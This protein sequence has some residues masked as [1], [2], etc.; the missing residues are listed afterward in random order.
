MLIIYNCIIVVMLKI[1]L[2]NRDNSYLFCL[3]LNEKPLM[4][5]HEGFVDLNY[6]KKRIYGKANATY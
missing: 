1:S 4:Q 3:K 2:K 5:A 6:Y